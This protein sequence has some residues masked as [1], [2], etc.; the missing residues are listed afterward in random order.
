[1]ASC[2]TKRIIKTVADAAGWKGKGGSDG[3]GRGFGFARYNNR[4]AYAAVIADIYIGDDADLRI[5]DVTIAVDAGQIID[6][7][8][9][10]LQIEGGI[11]QAASWMRYEQVN[12][13]GNEVTSRDWDSYPIIRFDNV[14]NIR[15]I[16]VDR[17]DLKPLGPSECSLSPTGAAIANAVYDAIGIRIAQAPYTPDAIRATAM[18]L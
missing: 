6:R 8:S 5:K 15:T 3:H 13:D 7:E 10:T 2:T 9:L 17:P 11:I 12:F 18:E 14:P 16:L 1:M 4:K